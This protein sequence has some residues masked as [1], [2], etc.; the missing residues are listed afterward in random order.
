[1]TSFYVIGKITITIRKKRNGTISCSEKNFTNSNLTPQRQKLFDR[2]ISMH[3]IVSQI[4]II[5]NP[6][7]L[8]CSFRK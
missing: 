5:I 7:A 1:M 6:R 2:M 4:K 8:M 3:E